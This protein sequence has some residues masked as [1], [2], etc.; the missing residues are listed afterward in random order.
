M[1][2]NVNGEILEAINKQNTQQ[3]GTTLAM[4]AIAEGLIK[5]DKHFEKMGSHTNIK[6]NEHEGDS[7]MDNTSEFEDIKKAKDAIV[8]ETALAVV[9]ILKKEKWSQDLHGDQFHNVNHKDVFYSG[10]GVTDA[11]TD[12]DLREDT[13]EVQK[14]LQLQELEKLLK[15][16]EKNMTKKL[17]TMQK[18]FLKE[19]ASQYE[20]DDAMLG[21]DVEEDV[22]TEDA[23]M[24]MEELGGAGGEMENDMMEGEMMDD[25]EFGM[26]ESAEYP[27]MDDEDDFEKMY[28]AMLKKN[29]KLEKSVNAKAKVMA[30]QM[31]KKQGFHKE[32]SKNPSKLQKGGKTLGLD[33]NPLKDAKDGNN[34][35]LVDIAKD[36]SGKG[37][38]E[39]ME[40]YMETMPYNPTFNQDLNS[41][42]EE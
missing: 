28:K 2:K 3:E 40:M 25:E 31:L 23:E 35:S 24:G 20:G 36:L 21:G 34:T 15:Q 13:G 33:P 32:A 22:M 4:N 38:N 1:D 16:M 19:H 10:G 12:A 6:K 14:P 29:Q 8:A 5:M 17:V 7:D 9:D 39:L 26:E 27:T 42:Y 37:W 41:L 11:Q 30:D 18:H